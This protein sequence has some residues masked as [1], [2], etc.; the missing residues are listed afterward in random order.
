MDSDGWLDLFVVNGHVHDRLSELGRDEPFAQQPQLFLNERGQRMRVAKES[1]SNYFGRSVVGR[2]TATA[3]FD[4]DGRPDLAVL[5]LNSPATLLRNESTGG[6]TLQVRLTGTHC[7]RDAIGAVV[8]VELTDRR[9]VRQ[10]NGST[11]YLSSDD[12]LLLI[13]IGDAQ[14]VARLTVRWPGGR[15]EQWE[16]LLVSE[17]HILIEGTGTPLA[18]EL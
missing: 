3:D 10:R 7:N 8:E 6:N 15:I 17:L 16:R 1:T 13:G 2:G 11:S 4:R 9:I 18:P 5:H 12:G 14:E